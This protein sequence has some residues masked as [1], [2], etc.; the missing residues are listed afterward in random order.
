MKGYDCTSHPYPQRR[1]TL[2]D[3]RRPLS[4]RLAW[5]VLF[6]CDPVTARKSGPDQHRVMCPFHSERN[7][8]CDVSL[9]KNAFICR[10]CNTRGGTLD[11]VIRGGRATTRSE[12]AQWLRDRGA[13]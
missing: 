11:A 8:S 12:A 5:I 1:V 7:P 6:G 10:S 9:A 4:I 13:L 2:R 3:A